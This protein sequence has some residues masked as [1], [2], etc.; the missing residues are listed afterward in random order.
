MRWS[1]LKRSLEDLLADAVK[2]H[3]Q[4]HFTRYGRSPNSMMERAW[5]TWDKVEVHNFST[6]GWLRGTHSVATQM[7]E[8]GERKEPPVWYDFSEEVVKRLEQSGVFSRQQWYDALQTY[9][10]LSIERALHSSNALIRA[11]AM[12]DR[13]L[14]KRRLRSMEFKPSDPSFVKRWYQLRCQAEGIPVGSAGY[15]HEGM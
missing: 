8:I 12:F 4:V 1:K 14:G 2:E 5:I 11:W 6:V 15:D 10:S 3:L 13:R 7:Y 9:L